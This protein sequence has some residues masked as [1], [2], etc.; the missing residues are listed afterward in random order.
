MVLPMSFPCI[1]ENRREASSTHVAN[2]KDKKN[3][4]D[5]LTRSKGRCETVYNIPTKMQC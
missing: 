4:E 5:F 3:P 2:I 1:A